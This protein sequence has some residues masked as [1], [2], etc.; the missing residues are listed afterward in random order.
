MRSCATLA[1]DQAFGE[2]HG[3]VDGGGESGLVGGAVAQERDVPH[4][5]EPPV[6]VGGEPD[7]RGPFPARRVRGSVVAAGRPA[8]PAV[9]G[10]P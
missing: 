7:E 6:R 10:V 1:V 3:L 9:D 5:A 2:L 8:R 4:V